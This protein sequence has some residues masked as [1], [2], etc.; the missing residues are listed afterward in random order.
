MTRATGERVVRW[1]SAERGS[2]GTPNST[3][4]GLSPAPAIPSN[5]DY[6]GPHAF[7]VSFQQSSTAKSATWT[8]DALRR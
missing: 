4:E 3:F 7:Q 8:F 5:T 2:S 1:H 6:P